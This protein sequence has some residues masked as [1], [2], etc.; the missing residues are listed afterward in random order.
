MCKHTNTIFSIVV[1]IIIISKNVLSYSITFIFVSV[2]TCGT[3]IYI[4]LAFK[5]I[6]SIMIIVKITIFIITISIIMSHS[7]V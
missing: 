2:I 5:S 7:N 1:T 4:D 6:I 3:N